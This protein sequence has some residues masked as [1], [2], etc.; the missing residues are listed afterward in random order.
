MTEMHETRPARR[1]WLLL[2]SG[3]LLLVFGWLL[4]SGS[5]AEATSPAGGAK[6]EVL[7][8]VDGVEIT[9]ADVRTAATGELEQL[10]TQRLVQEA[11][12]RQR[13]HEIMEATVNKMVEDRLFAAE[14]KARGVSVEDLIAQE[15]SSK[16]GEVTDAQVDAFYAERSTQQRLPPKEQIVDQIR[17][18]LSQQQQGG[19]REAFVASLRE[20]HGAKVLL[21]EYRTEVA[22]TGPAK[23]PADAPVT[24]VEFSDFECPFCS[25]ILPTIQQAQD[26]YG[27]KLRLV[28]RQFPLNS[29]HPSAQKAAEASL[30]ANDQGKF[31]EFHDAL[32]ANQKALGVD[33]LKATAETLGLDA[34]KFAACVEGGTHAATVAKDLREGMAAGVSGTPAMF[35]NGRFV[36]GLVPFEELKRI[37][38][39]EL[40]K[41]G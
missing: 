11:Q 20:K 41:K 1:G 27:D 21:G 34:A 22:A 36:N 25:R 14:A 16:V 31:W 32:F 15:I 23:G 12:F 18:Y 24:I 3:I 37:I 13:R 19:V 30:C 26:T 35:V 17:N 2:A 6:P 38:D 8:V 5:E 40:A 39:E 4:Q 7:A 29:I 10:E 9:D 33:Q 28:F